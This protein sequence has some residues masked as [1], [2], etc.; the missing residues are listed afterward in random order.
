MIKHLHCHWRCLQQRRTDIRLVMF[1]K[2]L[3]GIVALDLFPQLIPL[4]RPSLHKHSEAFQLPPITKQLIQ[5]R[6][7]PRTITCQP[8][9]LQHQV[10]RISDRKSPACNINW[11]YSFH[12][13]NFSSPQIAV[14]H[15]RYHLFSFF[16]IFYYFLL[17]HL[18]RGHTHRVYKP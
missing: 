1:F 3:H 13:I 10:W 8:M 14:L 11:Y 2:T 16:Q 6:F 17:K 15:A 12:A 18:A 4:V 7:L 5:Y 9:Q